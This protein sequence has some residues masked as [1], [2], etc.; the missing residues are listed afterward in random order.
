M[1]G[2]MNFQV[3]MWKVNFSAIIKPH[4]YDYV[5][6]FEELKNLTCL[7]VFKIMGLELTQDNLATFS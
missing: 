2:P 6:K 4:S 3:E 5:F 7:A 1:P